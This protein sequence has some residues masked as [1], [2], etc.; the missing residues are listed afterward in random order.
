MKNMKK[1]HNFFRYSSLTLTWMWLCIFSAVPYGL[2]LLASFLSHNASHLITLPFTFSNYWDVL[3]H[4]TYGKI[5]ERSFY[6]ASLSTFIC[7]ILGYPFAY[8]LAR[9]QSHF[10]GLLLL[11]VIIPFW[12]S[13]LIRSYSM[14]TIL[15]SKGLVN[16]LLLKLGLIEKPLSLLFNDLSVVIGLVYNLL[17]FMILPLLTNI[18]RLDHRL[19]DAARDLGANRFTTFRR[20]IL[21]LSFPGI[22]AGSIL[23]FLP[24]M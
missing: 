4:S 16:S 1:Q 9:M 17:P 12:T 21:P 13:S 22:I 20:I 23:V 8:L 2:I 5:L 7:L 6:L 15:K 14:I 24:A 19:I 3:T 10:K 18:E 11:L